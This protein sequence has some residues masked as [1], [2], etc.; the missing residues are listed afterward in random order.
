MVDRDP[1]GP[2]DGVR[3]ASTLSLSTARIKA[4][5][6]TVVRQ[7]SP[8]ARIAVCLGLV[9]AVVVGVSAL[10][11][12]PSATL[13]LVCRHDFR[14]VALTVS[15]DGEVVHSETLTGS[16]K[17]WLGVIEKTG[18]TYTRAIPVSSGQHVVE[19]RLRAPGFDRSRSI[20]AT[21]SRG[22]ESVLSVDTGR[23]LSLAWRQAANATNSSEAGGDGSSWNRNARSLLLTV[24][25]SIVSAT[26]GVLVQAAIRSRKAPLFGSKGG[27]GDNSQTIP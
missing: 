10:L 11:S 12:L 27:R 3:K 16:V 4:E 5:V 13:R 14:S 7:L 20:Q 25:G 24:F 17:K 26:I 18:G 21:F 8:R 23:D 22:R 15:I 19:V 2:S 6:G 1:A 9:G